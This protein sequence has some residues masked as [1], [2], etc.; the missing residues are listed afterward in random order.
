MAQLVITARSEALFASDLSAA[1]DASPAEVSAAIAAALI[2]HGGVHG[3][4]A[5]L[6]S[7]YG[8]HPETAVMR[9]QWALGAVRNAYPAATCRSGRHGDTAPA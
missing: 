5:R 6:A 7:E 4:A 8:E 3:C 1:Q 9:M 2:R